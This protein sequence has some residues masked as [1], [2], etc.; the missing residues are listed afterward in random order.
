[1]MQFINTCL[2]NSIVINIV[3]SPRMMTF[4]P[5]VNVLNKFQSRVISLLWKKQF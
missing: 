3:K 5:G 1:M 4:K 2:V